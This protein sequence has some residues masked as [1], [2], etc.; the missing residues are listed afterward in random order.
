VTTGG[1][2]G[3][4]TTA[5]SGTSGSGFYGLTT[6]AFA[7]KS[8]GG[9]EPHNFFAFT[10]RTLFGRILAKHQV[11]EIMVAFHAMVFVYGHFLSFI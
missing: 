4:R 2:T 6:T 5:A 9:H 11:F 1:T 8:T 7:Q 3:C 10:G